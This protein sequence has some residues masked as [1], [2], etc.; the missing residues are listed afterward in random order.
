MFA[1]FLKNLTRKGEEHNNYLPL[2]LKIREIFFLRAN[3]FMGHFMQYSI[4]PREQQETI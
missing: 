1:L 2:I 4:L 3:Y